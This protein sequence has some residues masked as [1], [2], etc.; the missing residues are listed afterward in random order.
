MSMAE[1]LNVSVPDEHAAFLE[2]R[3]ISPSALIQDA[4]ARRI[5][6]SNWSE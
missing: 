5:E 1:R 2:D 6:E 4:I 3:N